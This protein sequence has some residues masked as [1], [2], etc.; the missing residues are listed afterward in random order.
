MLERLGG[1]P[2]HDFMTRLD[3]EISRLRVMTWGQLK[4][5]ST[6]LLAT[7]FANCIQLYAW[8]F[9]PARL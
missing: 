4:I 8:P 5:P 1:R 7:T 2:S 9:L 6:P 3:L